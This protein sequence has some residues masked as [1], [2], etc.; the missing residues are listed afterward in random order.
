[1]VIQ[2]QSLDINWRTAAARWS[3]QG[4]RPML[5]LA[6]LLAAGTAAEPTLD[7]PSGLALRFGTIEAPGAIRAHDGWY[8]LAHELHAYAAG[9]LTAARSSAL[10]D[11]L[12]AIVAFN[13]MAASA[14]IKLLIV[15]VPGKIAVYPDKL[16]PAWN[17]DHR[18]DAEQL[19]FYQELR[20]HSVEVLDLLP[21]FLA[22]R[23]QGTEVFCRQDS[24]WSP[25]GMQLASEAIQH[26]MSTQ[27]WYAGV[28]QLA[29]TRVA[30]TIHANGD[31]ATLLADQ[32]APAEQLQV[33]RVESAGHTVPTD[34]QSPIVLMGDSFT[35]VYHGDGLLAE[36]A[37]LPDQLAA[38]C[39]S[40]IDLI[41][42]L[43]GGANGSRMIL[44]RRKDNL[45]G[46][47]CLIWVFAARELSESSDGWK[48]I[49]VVR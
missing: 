1:M 35:L 13:T 14:G 21:D 43:G 26:W 39:S 17:T 42:V 47:K 41:G 23:K 34:R 3:L 28:A 12:S 40:P 24:H 9:S 31:L 36:A 18:W 33:M 37:G 49:P 2:Y 6:L 22:M 44:A 8:F 32:S 46:K 30:Q 45:A 29:T 5:G 15:P 16:D 19:A 38:L 11:P 48:M 25:S 27:A 7:I 20:G 10:G 4:L